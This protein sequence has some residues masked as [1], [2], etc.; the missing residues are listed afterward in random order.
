MAMIQVDKAHFRAMQ[1][2]LTSAASFIAGFEGDENQE[3]IDKLI[4]GIR[5]AQASGDRAQHA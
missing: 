1:A 5:T 2:A 4:E 3:G